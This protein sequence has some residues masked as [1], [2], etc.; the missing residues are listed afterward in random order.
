MHNIMIEKQNPFFVFF[1][2][3]EKERKKKPVLDKSGNST[4]YSFMIVFWR[5]RRNALCWPLVYTLAKRMT[6]FRWSIGRDWDSVEVDDNISQRHPPHS[7]HFFDSISILLLSGYLYKTSLIT[8]LVLVF[9]L[10]YGGGGG[11][12]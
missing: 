6:F 3:E 7:K 4:D 12:A 9:W 10:I 5:K 11:G 8:S 1:E 2:E